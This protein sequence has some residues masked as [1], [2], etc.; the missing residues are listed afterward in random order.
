MRVWLGWVGLGWAI[1]SAGGLT[2]SPFLSTNVYP[3]HVL[4]YCHVFSVVTLP[5]SDRLFFT[6]V[7]SPG[8]QPILIQLKAKGLESFDSRIRIQDTGYSPK[9]I[10]LFHAEI[11]SWEAN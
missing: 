7:T 2:S 8:E 10:I 6:F 11:V 3:F 1:I 4:F 5:C 9:S